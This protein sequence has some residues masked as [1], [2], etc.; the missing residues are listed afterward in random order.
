MIEKYHQVEKNM[1]VIC[2][3]SG[4]KGCVDCLHGSPHEKVTQ[5]YYIRVKHVCTEW[6]RCFDGQGEIPVRCTNIR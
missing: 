3:K 6:T 4:D 5:Y 1:K 2:N